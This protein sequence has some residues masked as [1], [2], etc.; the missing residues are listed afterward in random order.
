MVKEHLFIFNEKTNKTFNYIINEITENDYYNIMPYKIENN[1]INFII[2]FNNDT[3][4]LIFY[5]YDFNLYEN[6]S[7]PKEIIIENMNIRNKMVR[8]QLNSY[9]SFIKCFYYSKINGENNYFS[10]SKFSI[11]NTNIQKEETKNITVENTI[12]QIKSAMS[13]NN[14][15]LICFFIIKNEKENKP[16]CY[17]NDY[18]TNELNKINCS[19]RNYGNGSK[20]FYFNETGD[21]MFISVKVLYT[22][23][24]NSFN[25]SMK[26]CNEKNIF[27]EQ[28]DQYSIIYNNGNYKVVNYTNF[29]NYGHCHNISILE[30]KISDSSLVSNI[31]IPKPIEGVTNK[32]KEEIFNNIDEFLED[33]HIGT[34]YKIKGDTFS[35]ILKPT[36]ST[37]LPNTTHVEF[38]E[39]EQRIRY[40]YIIYL[41]QVLLHFYN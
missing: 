33:K 14:N 13:Y 17:I 1:S 12:N 30:E 32:T 5:Y 28:S 31:S 41:I 21:F 24:F 37:P 16:F 10:Y 26:Y 18:E 22:T 39:C 15:F 20:V 35:I 29:I 40:I 27:N 9:K 38:D 4:S 25:N 8:C 6:I 19:Y 7:E 23:L 34:I 2:A 3:S 11:N 36:N